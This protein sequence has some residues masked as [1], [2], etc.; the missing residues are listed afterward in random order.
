MSQIKISEMTEKMSMGADDFFVVAEHVS[1][2]T[3]NTRK[4]RSSNV[5]PSGVVL[6]TTDQ[7][8]GGTKTFSSFPVSPSGVP[9]ADFEF[10][11]KKYVD[12]KGVGSDDVASIIMSIG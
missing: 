3:Y 11:N 12:S 9:T 8:I 2:E 7:T 6:Q 1:G 10:A 5:S 4:V